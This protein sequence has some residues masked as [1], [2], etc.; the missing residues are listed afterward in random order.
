VASVFKLDRNSP[1]PLYRQLYAQA[2]ERILSGALPPG[3]RLPPERTLARRLGVNRSTV[4]NAYRELAA[5]GLVEGRVGHG[6][7]V[8]GP[9]EPQAADAVRPMRWAGPTEAEE[10]LVADI[11]A[12]IRQPGAISFAH[13]E[14]AP[15][16]YP[17]EA[18]AALMQRALRDPTALGYGPIAGHMPLR[19]AIADAMGAKAD[20]VLI[21]AGSQI[22]LYLISRVLLQPGDTVLVEM[23][24]Y[25]NTLGI[26]DSAG[27]RVVPVPVDQ[28]G[29]VVDGLDELMLRYRP[30]LLFTLPTFHNPLGVTLTLERRRQLIQLAARHQVGIVEDDPYG[31]LHF[32]EQPVPT[33]KSLDPG[34]YV[35]YI[36]SASKTV[37]PALRLAW[38]LAAPPVVE[39][40]A[41]ARGNLDFRAALL[42]QRVMEAFIREGLLA[43]HLAR[44]RPA[45]KERRDRMLEALAR[46]MP[47]EVTWYVP[48]G[49]YHIWCLLPRPLT[50]RRLLIEAGREGVAFVPGDFYGAGPLAR[51]GLRL[52]FSYPRPEEIEP[53][54]A[55][56]ARA[57]ERLLREE[58]APPGEPA[59]ISGPVV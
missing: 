8:L 20:E 42:N 7:V 4:V 52:N 22:A 16:L 2:K 56:L 57:A 50:A 25:I 19:Q 18:L 10:P 38:I 28:H 14:M 48:E 46:H 1:I 49:G 5:E 15:D 47:K 33:L 17:A 26:F 55:R 31:P 34:G 37:S 35:I 27:V 58:A 3:T 39:R 54:I 6:T 13:G 41:R 24:S 45:L 36:S 23:P 51:R 32:A 53:G 40:I 43:E 9:P 12:I 44:L 11:N 59:P 21:L 29:L 30:K